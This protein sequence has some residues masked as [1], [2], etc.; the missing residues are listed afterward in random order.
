MITGSRTTLTKKY[1]ILQRKLTV[2]SQKT[3]KLYDSNWTYKDVHTYIG[4]ISDYTKFDPKIIS[5]KEINLYDL[6]L[7]SQGNYTLPWKL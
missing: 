4:T 1:S 5:I 3:E 7:D 2:E 6:T